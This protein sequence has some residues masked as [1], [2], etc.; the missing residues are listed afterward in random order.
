MSSNYKHPKP[1]HLLTLEPTVIS[2]VTSALLMKPSNP[3]SL[4]V[5]PVSPQQPGNNRKP[6]VLTCL[7]VPFS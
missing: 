2:D 7:L 6:N 3:A 4:L 5:A 1:Y